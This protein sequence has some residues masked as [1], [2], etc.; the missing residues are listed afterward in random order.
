MG[1]PVK[2]RYDASRRRA[3][4]DAT[5]ERICAA[6]EELFL[7]DGYARASIRAVAREAGVAEATVYL[8]FSTKAALLDATILRATGADEGKP[9]SALLDAPPA[10]L[11]GRL[12]NA[13]AAAMSRA[14]RLIALGESAV[15]MD[16]ALRPLRDRAHANLR[17]AYAAIAQR[18]A[19]ARLLRADLTAADAA[20]TLYAIC[21]ETTYLRITDNGARD[22]DRYAT[23]LTATLE[24]TLLR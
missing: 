8:V 20:D 3:A 5:R 13:H 1:R 17:A 22:P 4:A 6:A 19:D 11:L 9:F 15:L 10:T 7:R 16:A 18:L 23:W 12:A 21:N 2:R 14:A 24:A